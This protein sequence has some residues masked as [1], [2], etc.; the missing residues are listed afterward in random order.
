MQ[1]MKDFIDKV[2]R[3]TANEYNKMVRSYAHDY[4][5]QFNREFM[6]SWNAQR[7]Q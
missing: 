7:L 3:S 1:D 5:D 2:D 6:N 4:L